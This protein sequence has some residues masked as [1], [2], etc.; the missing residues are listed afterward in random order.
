MGAAAVVIVAVDGWGAFLRSLAGGGGSCHGRE[1]M[2]SGMEQERGGRLR[3]IYHTFKVRRP[4]G[5]KVELNLI[6]EYVRHHMP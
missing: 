3:V 1:W 6:F 4:R 5:I 2:G